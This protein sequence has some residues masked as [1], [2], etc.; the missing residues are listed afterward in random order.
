MS[1]KITVTALP[2]TTEF[3]VGS[4]AEGIAILE[5][6]N[7][8]LHKMLALSTELQGIAV[9]GGGTIA[10]TE[11]DTDDSGAPKQRGRK[12]NAQKAAEAKAAEEAA[13]KAAAATA[14]IPVAIPGVAGP[15]DTTT[16]ADNGVPAFLNR[17]E[18]TLPPV[19]VTPPPALPPVA[20]PPPVV[21]APSGILA[22]K[23]IA[24]L[25]TRCGG[26]AANVG[27]ALVTWLSAPPLLLVAP[28][29]SYAD[30]IDAIRLMPD[31]KLA[32]VAKALEV[33]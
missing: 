32:A 8:A 24:N 19:A 16:V 9:A 17:V 15:V 2:L 3:E 23:V 33:A 7:T 14:P 1:F 6:Q 28:G 4:L 30:A 13:A 20:P 5:E 18:T 12:S 25:D 29:S 10:T 26:D 27:P 22:G 31:D 21:A 11:T